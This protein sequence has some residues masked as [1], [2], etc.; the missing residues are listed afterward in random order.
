LQTV[1]T[2]VSALKVT[3][4]PD[5]PFSDPSRFRQIMDALQYLTFI[6]PDICF[7]VNRVCQFMHSPTDSR[8]AAIKRI[9]RYL[10]GTSS[11]GFHVTQGSFF[12]LH[13]FT[14]QIGLVV[15]MIASLDSQQVR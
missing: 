13:G 10:K 1:D 6:Q 3:I 2:P 15:L 9:L 7:F 5:N 14:V 11:Y 4:L 12:A 8:W